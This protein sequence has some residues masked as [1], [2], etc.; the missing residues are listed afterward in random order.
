MRLVLVCGKKQKLEP[1]AAAPA[2]G[3]EMANR[4]EQVLSSSS[5][6]SPTCQ[7]PKEAASRGEMELTEPHSRAKP[8][9]DGGLGARP[10]FTRLWE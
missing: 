3:A 4:K 2:V 8:S 6:E 9:V 5:F 1:A 10:V 7:G